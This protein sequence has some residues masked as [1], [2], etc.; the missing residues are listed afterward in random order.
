[1]HQNVVQCIKSPQS[2]D[3]IIISCFTYF[4]FSS[5]S[6]FNFNMKKKETSLFSPTVCCSSGKSCRRSR[7]CVWSTNRPLS[8]LQ[9]KASRTPHSWL[10]CG[11]SG[12]NLHHSC[13]AAF[14][15]L[16]Q[17]Q[18]RWSRWRSA[19]TLRFS[20]LKPTLKDFFVLNNESDM[21][22]GNYKFYSSSVA[23]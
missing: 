17:L 9:R 7:G 21:L 23:Y 10:N 13:S 4:T 2:S 19:V 16:R 1:M 20:L 3:I 8:R 11:C 15:K 22:M 6:W 12:T 14:K 5:S 18:G